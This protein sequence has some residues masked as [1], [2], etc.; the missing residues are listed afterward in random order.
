[1]LERIAKAARIPGQKGAKADS[2]V[3]KVRYTVQRGAVSG[4][5]STVNRINGTA[6]PSLV[7]RQSDDRNAGLTVARRM[8]P[9]L[10]DVA[11]P[12]GVHE[13]EGDVVVT[14]PPAEGA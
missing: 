6:M 1:M 10:D 11:R 3:G 12:G 5:S 13:G 8:R 2:K 14:A 9:D 4:T 7:P